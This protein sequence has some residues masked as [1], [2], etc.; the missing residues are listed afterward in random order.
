[1]SNSSDDNASDIEFE[2]ELPEDETPTEVEDR[3]E[4]QDIP[5]E[6][7]EV[8]GSDTELRIYLS[9]VGRSTLLSR[10]VE[11][12]LGADMY[13]ARREMLTQ[14]TR[15]PA[16][17]EYIAGIHQRIES[18]QIS[19]RTVYASN[20]SAEETHEAY[21]KGLA[22]RATKLRRLVSRRSSS[23]SG[24]GRKV[25]SADIDSEICDTIEGMS[26]NWSVVAAF[27]TDA[28]RIVA[29]ATGMARELSRTA[30]N[31]GMQPD[32]LIH[33]EQKP[34]RSYVPAREWEFAQAQ[35]RR[36]A[37]ELDN[38]FAEL[39]APKAVVEHVMRKVSRASARLNAAR[40]RM[41]EAN[42]RL[43]V[44]I[45]K[46]YRQVSAL[47]FLD[48]IQEGNIGLMRAVD[49]FDAS[50]GNKFSTYAT[51]WV[52]QAIT[53]A[54]A[55]IGRT[56]RIPVHMSEQMLKVSRARR[57]YTSSHGRQPTSA[58]LSEH[59]GGA[60]SAEQIRRVAQYAQPMVMLDAPL[61]HEESSHTSTIGDTMADTTS[62]S[63][64]QDMEA[65]FFKDEVARVIDS[66]SEKEARIIRLRFGIGHFSEHTL[67]EVGRVFGLTR[68]RI[69]QIEY[70]ALVK[71]KQRNR[72]IRLRDYVD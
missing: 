8:D 16:F 33:A 21:L 6:A 13:A 41:T 9:M 69:R 72:S 27:I 36:M 56:I 23:E 62:G 5:R 14:L 52:R 46:R 57:E 68:E 17:V 15:L 42:L 70:Q 19:V 45:A 3:D 32:E 34:R 60:V 54:I 47:G 18:K 1:M 51:W 44:S 43:V 66:L 20:F 4:G 49:K 35:A 58:E 30:A 64:D 25:R 50:R 63:T 22:A 12:Q 61:D 40:T 31:V 53:R 2:G 29:T 67:E 7:Q 48:L 24:S 26:L 37:S 11:Q 39:G 38:A 65:S 10:D 55:D 71:L 59:M 28:E